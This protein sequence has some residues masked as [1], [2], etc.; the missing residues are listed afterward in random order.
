MRKKTKTFNFPER[1]KWLKDNDPRFKDL[2]IGLHPVDISGI[3]YLEGLM[4]KFRHP[5]EQSFVNVARINDPGNIFFKDSAIYVY[6]RADYSPEFHEPHFFVNLQNKE[7]QNIIFKI[8]DLNSP[9][10]FL[11][12][13]WDF[14]KISKYDRAPLKAQIIRWLSV[15]NYKDPLH[16]NHEMLVIEWNLLN[17]DNPNVLQMEWYRGPS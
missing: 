11:E 1:L 8:P 10:L 15:L 6:G 7:K 3:P 5:D 14:D 12:I 4:V 16:S 17:K 9:V 13:L 2:D